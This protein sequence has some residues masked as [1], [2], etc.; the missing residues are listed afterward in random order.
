MNRDEEYFR[1]LVAEKA[2]VR[3]HDGRPCVSWEL[4]ESG[5]RNEV[6]DLHVY[7]LAALY[8]SNVNLERWAEE[9]KRIPSPPPKKEEKKQAPHIPVRKD[10]LRK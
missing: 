3:I 7:G 5:R 10:W 2:V 6:L 4:R 1:M 8:I 9:L